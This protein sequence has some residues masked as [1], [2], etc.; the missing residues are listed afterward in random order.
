MVEWHT[1]AT[2][3]RVSQGMR[4]RLPPAPLMQAKI[5]CGKGNCET[6]VWNGEVSDST[7]INRITLPKIIEDISQSDACDNHHKKTQHKVGNLRING[8]TP[9][10]LVADKTV[11]GLITRNTSKEWEIRSKFPQDIL[12]EIPP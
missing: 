6:S 4:V 9:F 7:V 12:L 1:R 5:I 10:L 8:H 2:Q 3:N 11:I